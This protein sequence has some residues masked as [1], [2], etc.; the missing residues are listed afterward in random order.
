MKQKQ[1]F[2]GLPV[3]SVE[4]ILEIDFDKIIICSVAYNEIMSQLLHIGIPLDKIENKY[5][6]HTKRF[7][8]KYCA[9]K[10]ADDNEILEVVEYV[11]NH[12][13]AVFNYP[14][15]DEYNSY[16]VEVFFDIQKKLYYIWYRGKKM[17]MSRKYTEISQV[18]KYV[19]S[20]LKEQSL[21]SPH[22]YLTEDFCVDRGSIV[23]DVGV[24]EGNFALDVIDYVQKIYLVE[25]DTDWVEALEYTFEPYKEKVTIINRYMGAQD[26]SDMITMDTMLQGAKIDFLKM[27]IEGAE[28]EALK[29][30]RQTINQTH[31]KMDICTYHRIED[32]K[33]IGEFLKQFGYHCEHSNGYMVFL[34]DE[35]FQD[36]NVKQLVRGLIRAW[37]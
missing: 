24:A 23:V 36:T 8:N 9:K 11:K 1:G 22:R 14:F 26:G 5:Y 33:K 10:Y 7:L 17:Y 12:G 6:F 29:G 18:Q 19:R 15:N 25:A 28:I 16:P 13:L 3:L 21:N 4:E 35:T 32:E 34:V 27:D 2:L 37:K 20:I 30:A 31:L